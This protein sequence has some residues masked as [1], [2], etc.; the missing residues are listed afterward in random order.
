MLGDVHQ[1]TILDVG[2]RPDPDT[3]DIAPHHSAKPEGNILPQNDIAD[4]C[5]I[6]GNPPAFADLGLI[7][8]VW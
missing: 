6:G 7:I 3:V 4:Q 2:A 1:R 5:G 8:T